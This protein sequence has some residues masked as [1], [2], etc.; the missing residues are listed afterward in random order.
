MLQKPVFHG[1][2]GYLLFSQMCPMPNDY[3]KTAPQYIIPTRALNAYAKFMANI[4]IPV[5]KNRLIRNFIKDYGVNMSEAREESIDS[6]S[7]FNDF[8]I[9]HLKPECRPV[10]D[11]GIVSPV[12]GA[13]S[14][15]GAITAGKMLQAKGRDYTVSE[16]LAC[17]DELSSQFSDGR[18]ATIYLSPKDYHRIHMPIEATLREMI[19]V[20][21][22]LFSVQPTTARVVPRLFARNERLVVFFDTPVGLMA[23][24]L[25][26]AMVVGAIG[27][28]WHGDIRRS[29]KPSRFSYQDAN[30]I[31]Q[32]SA[33]MGYFKLGST[34]VLLFADSQRMEWNS[35]LQAGDNIRLGEALADIK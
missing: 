6:Y 22:K 16:L 1:I 19:Y 10:S 12:D 15:I 29:R 17:E 18:F 13:I 11:A 30:T 8:F 4:K 24:V 35:D 31:L 25:V 20:P 33:E 28:T 21:G 9:R 23:M 14:E 5:I 3:L 7:C 26:G 32:K 2:M 34:V 27:T